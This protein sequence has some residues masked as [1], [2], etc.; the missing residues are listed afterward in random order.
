MTDV[1][2]AHE[3]EDEGVMDVAAE[4]EVKDKCMMDVAV[5]PRPRTRA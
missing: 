1:T 3:A 4:H 5:A 2:T